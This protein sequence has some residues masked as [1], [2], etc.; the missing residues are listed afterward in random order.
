[1]RH[2]DQRRALALPEHVPRFRADGLGRG[3]AR[4]GRGGARALHAG[5][6]VSLVVVTDVEHVVVSL[7]HPR[8][9]RHADVHG[10]AVAALADDA[11]VLAALRPQRR[12]DSRRYGGR[13]PEQRVDPRDPPRGLRV[14][15]GEHL[16]AAGRVR[17]DHLPVCGAHRGVQRVARTEGLPAALAGAVPA[18]D[19]V[20]PLLAGL[21]GA[22]LG[23]EQA[24]ADREAARLVE[25]DRWRLHARSLLIPAPPPRPRHRAGCS[26]RADRR[27]ARSPSA[28]APGSPRPNP[29]PGTSMAPGDRPPRR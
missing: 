27:R 7:E 23:I 2:R 25:A 29:C 20:R 22:L 19:R 3:G 6:H 1:M 17:G 11:H 12:G 24:I 10:A 15:G 26:R 9:A 16:Q 14:G 21:H 5:V 18:G 8:Q 13:V 4:G 28:R